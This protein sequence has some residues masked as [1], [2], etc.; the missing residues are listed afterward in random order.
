MRCK[1]LVFCSLLVAVVASLLAA[2]P[3]G[4]GA[5]A[6]N[7]ANDTTAT[8]QEILR[9]AGVA[10]DPAGVV[11]YLR[12]MVLSEADRAKIEGLVQ[13]LAGERFAAREEATEKLV[14]IGQPAVSFLRVAAR[15]SNRE[16][17]SRAD[18]CLSEIEHLPDPATTAAA[19]RLLARRPNGDALKTV[20]DY[21]PFA[22]DEGV[23]EESL[24]ALGLLGMKQGKPDPLL[25]AALKDSLPARRGAAGCVLARLGDLEQRGTVRQM[26][27]DTDARVRYFVGKGLLGD[28]YPKPETP[29]NVDDKKFLKAANI[30]SDAAG[31]IGFFKKRTLSDDDR[32]NLEKLVMQL[33]S[34]QFAQRQ[35]ASQRLVEIGTPALP[36][37]RNA[38]LGNSLEMTRRVE[39]CIKQIER[40]PG[41][42]LPSAAARLLAQRAP[43]EAI[44][45]LLDYVPFADDAS[46]ED[47]VVA[48]LG[49]LSA[50]EPKVPPALVAVLKDDLAPRRAVAALVLGQI[51]DKDNFDVVRELLK[52]SDARVRIRTAQGL[53]AA[54][55]KSAVPALLGLLGEG[56]VPQATLAE[57]LLQGIAGEK[58]PVLSISDTGEDA[59]KKAHESWVAWWRDN[60]DKI[61]LGAPD[62]GRPHLGLTI[63]A[64]L[65]G[66]ANSNRVWEFGT[67]GKERWSIGN[68]L[69]PIDA[70]VLKGN[71]VLIAEH[72][73][74]KVTERDMT[75]KVLWEKMVNG[76]PVSCQRLANGNTFI[77][78][79]TGVLEVTAAGKVVFEHNN[80]NNARGIIYDAVKLA[81]GNFT[82]ICGIGTLVEMDPAG[83]QVRSIQVGQNINW[84][85]LE[86]LPGGRYLVSLSNPGTVKEIDANGKSLWEAQVAGAAHATR[87]PNGNTIVACMNN[88]KL[89]EVNRTGKEVWSKTT[90]GRPFH[91]HRR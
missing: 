76:T 89:V 9:S 14:A 28:R 78:H 48:A 35:E 17:A 4:A 30:T 36:F 91:V 66:N 22:G 3:N 33:D 15:S 70:Q 40:G 1:L 87:L 64:E 25:L 80:I 44:Q 58:A 29:L 77:A 34:N 72:G 21:L 59:R 57:T 82:F 24:N 85:G 12:K 8:D 43:A 50:Q 68:L 2:P 67:D 41:P 39:E 63:V 31:L 74:R 45:V 73:A 26:L 60:A 54:K 53:L 69:N 83:K 51:G 88:Q 81:N 5:D 90:N 47:E 27:A 46:V 6:S 56:P 11:A 38:V 37:L 49:V 61:D 19:L 10:T 42:A 32:K 7:P 62:L 84:G 16:M 18:I 71:R 23:E 75:G 86:V 79:Y 20:L 55:D 52:D 13:Q 65:P